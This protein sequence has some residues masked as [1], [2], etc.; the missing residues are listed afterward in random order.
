MLLRIGG[1]MLLLV[2][3]LIVI[4]PL[5][6]VFFTS[7][8]TSTEFYMNPLGLPDALSL[9]N[10]AAMFRDQPMTGYFANSVAVTAAALLLELFLASMIA[11]GITRARGRAGRA[12][13]ALFAFGLMVPSQV[14][15]IPLYSLVR[16]LGGSDSLSSLVLVTVSFLMP[17]SVFILAGFMRSLSR[18]LLEAG[19]I[20]GAGEWVL[21]SRIALPLTA[22]ALA[23]TAAFVMVSVW[24]DLLFPML[25]LSQKAKMTLPLALL[26]FRG[27]YVIDYPM[28]LT[29]VVVTSVPM[30]ILFLFLQ[31]FFIS[32]MT[33]GSLKG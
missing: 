6:L 29:G 12:L 13:H 27:E 2:Y 8:K 26:Q 14:N 3:S 7:F 33:A 15:M 9:A 10:F 32:G 25:F 5:M 31:K 18:E 4:A 22:P 1:K 28:L 11:Y 16:G 21:F 30:V 17:I 23:T 24:N 19:S 20:D